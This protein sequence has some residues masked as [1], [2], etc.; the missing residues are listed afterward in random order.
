MQGVHAIS[1]TMLVDT[2]VYVCVCVYLCMYVC[3]YVFVCMT[4]K[5]DII[6]IQCMCII[7]Y[8]HYITFHYISY[9]Y[10]ELQSLHSTTI[11]YRTNSTV[12]PNRQQNPGEFDIHRA[13]EG[14][15]SSRCFTCR[16]RIQIHVNL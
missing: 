8:I 9:Y 16:R 1:I 4:Y 2:H 7:V 5:H 10:H 11:A 6:H 15:R 13:G 14:V 12:L 3:M